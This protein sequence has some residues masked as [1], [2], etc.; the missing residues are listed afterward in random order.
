MS[1]SQTKGKNQQLIVILIS[2][3]LMLGMSF[4]QDHK[5]WNLG[6]GYCDLFVIC[7]LVIVF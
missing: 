4:L 2:P 5:V 3:I 7:F 6:F 1:K